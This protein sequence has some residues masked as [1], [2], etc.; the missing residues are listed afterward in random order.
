MG[1][2]VPPDVLLSRELPGR[3][4]ACVH[5]PLLATW[6][7]R[8]RSVLRPGH[9]P[10]PGLCGGTDRRRQRPQPVRP[11]AHRSE[12]RATDP[13]AGRDPA[14]GPSTGVERRVGRLA[15]VGRPSE[16]GSRRTRCPRPARRLTRRPRCGLGAGACR[17]GPRVPPA[18]ARTAAV[19][20]LDAAPRRSDRPLP[21]RRHHRHPA[22][23]ERVVPLGSH[24]QYVQHG[25]ALCA[26]LRTADRVHLAGAGRVRRPLEQARPPV[27]RSSA[28]DRGGRPARR[29]PRR[30]AA[31]LARP[32]GN[33]A[34]RTGLGWS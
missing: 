12:G 34:V 16:R 11:S 24:A 23:E 18:H 31:G 33:A 28:L 32:F 20:P 14:G 25:P 19:R 8:P 6:R 17:S 27:P 30:R 26:R 3:P 7:R 13:G 15:R 29:R 1:P 4:R 9:D 10:A 22:R 21:G 2:R 5:R